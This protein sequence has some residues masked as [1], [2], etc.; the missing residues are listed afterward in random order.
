MSVGY[1]LC[2]AH[3][4]FVFFCSMDLDLCM[5]FFHC[6]FHIK[7]CYN[8]RYVQRTESWDYSV[9]WLRVVGWVAAYL[10]GITRYVGGWVCYSSTLSQLWTASCNVSGTRILT[11]SQMLKLRRNTNLLTFNFSM[12]RC[13]GYLSSSMKLTSYYDT[14]WI[15]CHKMLNSLSCFSIN[16]SHKY[17][18]V[19]HSSNNSHDTSSTSM[20]SWGNSVF[21]QSR[22]LP[23]SWNIFMHTLMLEV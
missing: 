13:E 22:A 1:F 19:N 9:P 12:F 3:C 4:V 8:L 16:S 2:M 21:H 18:S 11:F 6:F 15:L 10:S 23:F 7:C 14:I 5:W 17:L 20:F